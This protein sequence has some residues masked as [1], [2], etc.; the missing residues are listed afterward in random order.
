MHERVFYGKVVLLL[1]LVDC[2]YTVLT[3]I[4]QIHCACMGF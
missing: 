1:L 4:L 3:A 2:F